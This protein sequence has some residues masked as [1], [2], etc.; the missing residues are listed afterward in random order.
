MQMTVWPVD[1]ITE[2]YTAAVNSCSRYVETW[3]DF[4]RLRSF[5]LFA[6]VHIVYMGTFT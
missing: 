6:D 3:L 5:L 1:F 2:I 4:L